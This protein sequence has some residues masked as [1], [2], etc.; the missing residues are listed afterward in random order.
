MSS[1]NVLIVGATGNFGS[2]ISKE[3]SNSGCDVINMP[4]LDITDI[5]DIEHFFKESKNSFNHLV[6]SIGTPI[7]FR[8]ISEED[9]GDFIEQF[10]V[11]VN[12]LLIM[13]KEILK[14]NALQSILVIG[15]TSVF[16]QP[17]SRLAS[18]TTA[19]YALLGFTRSLTMELAPKNIRVNMISPGLSG[20]GLSKDHPEV[21]L[22]AIRSQTPLKRLVT[23]KDVALVAKFLLSKDAEYLTGLNI[24]MDGGLHLV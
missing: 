6:Y 4:R 5:K 19:K 20:Q 8:K 13:V 15:S 10:N 23:A 1:S 7:K 12:G 17:P 9:P 21:L 2:E 16:N 18:Y 22:N 24:P 14:T 11:Q 3:L